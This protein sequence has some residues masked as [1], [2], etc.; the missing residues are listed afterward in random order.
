[1]KDF[2]QIILCTVSLKN[3]SM[4]DIQLVSLFIFPSTNTNP[5]P[6]AR[7]SARSW[8]SSHPQGNAEP[9]LPEPVPGGEDSQHTL[10]SG[11]LAP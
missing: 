4:K 9:A 1:M 10:N 7:S 2:A 8:V 11:S 5:M 3:I 6:V